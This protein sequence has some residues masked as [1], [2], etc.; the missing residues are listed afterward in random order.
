M[1]VGAATGNHETS[2]V[3]LVNDAG[4]GGRTGLLHDL[5]CVPVLIVLD[6][7]Q[8]GRDL[9]GAVESPVPVD[10][11]AVILGEGAGADHRVVRRRD[12]HQAAHEGAVIPAAAA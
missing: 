2:W 6:G 11:A 1:E 8:R 7:L 5:E 10:D 4:E 9:P 12:A 3:L